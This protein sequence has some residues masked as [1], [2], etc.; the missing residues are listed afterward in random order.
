DSKRHRLG[1]TDSL[2][3]VRG[4]IWFSG[5]WHLLALPDRALLDTI[6]NHI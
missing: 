2:R 5:N 3:R 1:K 6:T 4:D